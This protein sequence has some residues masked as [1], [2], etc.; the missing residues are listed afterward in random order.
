[1]RTL[2]FYITQK[3]QNFSEWSIAHKETKTVNNQEIDPNT[4]FCPS[5]RIVFLHEQTF[6]W[7]MAHFEYDLQY[8]KSI[9]LMFLWNWEVSIFTGWSDK[10]Y[11]GADKISKFYLNLL[12]N[13]FKSN[14][15]RK[16][17]TFGFIEFKFFQ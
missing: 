11:T 13:G 3:I 14:I 6:S 15:K 4:S 10:I 8:W 1:M 7:I 16:I 17:F 5:Q 9:L 12:K 2:V